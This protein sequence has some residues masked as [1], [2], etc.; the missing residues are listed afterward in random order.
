M[1]VQTNDLPHFTLKSMGVPQVRSRVLKAW[2]ITIT[3][4]IHPHQC[5]VPF[6]PRLTSLL[7]LRGTP[8]TWSVVNSSQRLQQCYTHTRWS[9]HCSPWLQ[10]RVIKIMQANYAMSYISNYRVLSWPP[11]IRLML[12]CIISKGDMV[13]KCFLLSII[14]STHWHSNGFVLSKTRFGKYSLIPARPWWFR[15]WDTWCQYNTQ[16]SST[17]TWLYWASV[18][19]H[20][21]SST[22]EIAVCRSDQID[23]DCIPCQLIHL[24]VPQLSRPSTTQ[25][26]YLQWQRF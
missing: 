14:S 12:I 24:H 5:R 16:W 11:L 19:Q 7:C 26:G 13:W 3:T 8:K 18:G 6:P 22:S 9:T 2:S 21:T 20:C 23:H 10:M 4:T 15:Q 17:A 25:L 1:R